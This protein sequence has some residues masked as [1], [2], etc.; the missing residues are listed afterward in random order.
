M[1]MV[2]LLPNNHNIYAKDNTTVY[3]HIFEANLGTQYA[4]VIV[5]FTC[6]ANR[7]VA[8]LFLKTQFAGPA[9]WYQVI[10]VIMNLLVN[11]KW[12]CNTVFSLQAFLKQHSA[13]YTMLQFCSDHGQQQLPDTRQRFKWVMDNVDCEDSDVRAALYSIR[14]DYAPN[15]LSNEFDSP[16]AFLWPTNLVPK[17]KKEIIYT[18]KMFAMN[19]DEK[20]TDGGKFPKKQNSTQGRNQDGNLKSGVVKYGNPLC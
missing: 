2:H 17:K 18:A 9:C 12:T 13:T 14:I 4:T 8:C 15:S 5:P 19:E 16:V 3:R 10:K 20:K 6:A 11:R 7:R 1:E